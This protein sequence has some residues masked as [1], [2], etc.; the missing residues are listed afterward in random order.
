MLKYFFAAIIIFLVFVVNVIKNKIYK[1]ILFILKMVL[2]VL[3]L[4]VTV[5]N[6]NSYRTD[7]GKQKYIDFYGNDL[8]EKINLTTEETQ[9]IFIDN[10]NTKV[11]SIYLELGKLEDDE[12]VDYDIFYSDKSTSERYL[13]SKTYCQD[14][15]KTKYSVVS[16][17]RRLQKYRN[18]CEKQ[19]CQNCSELL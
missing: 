12:V 17:S 8:E 5:F 2:I 1:N 4:E 14:V 19:R 11:K 3:F 18:K 9:Y 13:A 6:I 16:L 15:D 7:F 10:L